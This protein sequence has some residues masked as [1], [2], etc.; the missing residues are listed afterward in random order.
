MANKY[1]EMINDLLQ[2]MAN[3]N[4][5]EGNRDK[6]A[7][8]LAECDTKR[9]RN[10]LF[11]HI[12]KRYS[13]ATPDLTQYKELIGHFD[14]FNGVFEHENELY[15][16]ANGDSDKKD[17]E[18]FKDMN[19]KDIKSLDE[20]YRFLFGKDN[21]S[22]MRAMSSEDFMDKYYGDKSELKVDDVIEALNMMS[23]M[24]S[25]NTKM[26]RVKKLYDSYKYLSDRSELA[27]VAG[28]PFDE[29]SERNF[30]FFR[31][32]V[33]E[34][35]EVKSGSITK[36]ISIVDKIKKSESSVLA[37]PSVDSLCKAYNDLRLHSL[38]RRDKE[39]TT[40][41]LQEFINTYLSPVLNTIGE[42]PKQSAELEDFKKNIILQNNNLTDVQKDF[43]GKVIDK[44]NTD[45]KVK[46]NYSKE[47]K[48]LVDMI[49]KRTNGYC[50]ITTMHEK[51][52]AELQK[53][54][55]K[56]QMGKEINDW[57]FNGFQKNVNVGNMI[58]GRLMCYN[59][60]DFESEGKLLQSEQARGKEA[61]S[62]LEKLQQDTV[63]KLDQA[64][65]QPIDVATINTQTGKQFTPQQ[66]KNNIV[67]DV[68]GFRHDPSGDSTTYYQQSK[69]LY[70]RLG[71]LYDAAM[72]R[73]EKGTEKEIK[74]EPKPKEKEI[75]E[76]PAP[77]T[78]TEPKIVEE[79]PS[80]KKPTPRLATGK[81]RTKISTKKRS[82]F[83]RA[84]EWFGRNFWVV[85]IPAVA[86]AIGFGLFSGMTSVMLVAG[87]AVAGLTQGIAYIV[88][89]YREF[90]ARG[91]NEVRCRRIENN[92]RKAARLNERLSE[93]T[94]DVLAEESQVSRS[95]KKSVKHI[96][97]QVETTTKKIQKNSTKIE[98]T[99]NTIT[100]EDDYHRFK[101]QQKDAV[102]ATKTFRE[103]GREHKDIVSEADNIYRPK[104][105]RKVRKHEG[106][107]TTKDT[108]IER[109]FKAK[110]AN[111]AYLRPTKTTETKET[112]VVDT[113]DDERT[114]GD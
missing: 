45:I 74:E 32:F 6:F 106:A 80:E 78:T 95:T 33:E 17:S 84:A 38:D 43:I 69:E 47:E 98:K 76:D 30:D 19:E 24:K 29:L 58:D 97:H 111:N 8:I 90:T 96:E 28:K 114:L 20:K 46:G 39:T 41:A 89:K 7:S 14:A 18:T 25:L 104:R 34:V 5:S 102:V 57:L 60:I 75:V 4:V 63:K 81:P 79:V 67:L 44:V 101:E 92:C 83:R 21:Y 105:K 37:K 15:S 50:T 40:A 94:E 26:D 53:V 36:K 72:A 2:Q 31:P 87:A 68:L 113:R 11:N 35:V 13:N 85:A 52:V 65:A 70:N 1:E 61:L 27:D 73:E 10:S 49:N 99:L 86:V 48:A 16:I 54:L 110:E 3:G 88:P 66:I 71:M 62:A 77:K 23:N 9:K 51:F 109:Y 59:Y 55:D 91:R 103:V 108:L 56:H 100:N 107:E 82:W 12:Y 112:E 64:L 42:A 22:I 93:I